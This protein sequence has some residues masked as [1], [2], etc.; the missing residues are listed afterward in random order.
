MQIK[1]R[2]HMMIALVAIV[3]A[4]LFGGFF[5]AESFTNSD[6]QVADAEV[7]E[8]EVT[9]MGIPYIMDENGNKHFS[10]EITDSI[11]INDSVE[12]TSP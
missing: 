4:V 8:V 12:V 5:M 7:S 1:N 2:K 6:V 10:A 3:P 11:S 9:S